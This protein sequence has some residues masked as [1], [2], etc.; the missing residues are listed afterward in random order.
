MLD[1][2]INEEIKIL[3]ELQLRSKSI[4]K[5]FDHINKHILVGGKIIWLGNGGS[6]T[7]SMHFS[8]ELVGKYKYNRKPIASIAL[9]DNMA[10]ITAIAN[11]INYETIFLRQL[12]AIAGKMDVVIMLSTSGK[13]MNISTALTWCKEKELYTVLITGENAPDSILEKATDVITV[14]SQSTSRI[15]ESYFLIC[16]SLCEYLE[17][18]MEE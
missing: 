2:N 8:A 1:R 9:T 3:R 4:Y 13:S 12:E 15:Q 5:V 18:K 14:C 6:A 11:D 17:E 7:D 16:H 10:V